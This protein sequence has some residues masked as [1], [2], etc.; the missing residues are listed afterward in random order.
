MKLIVEGR[1]QSTSATMLPQRKLQNLI[2]KLHEEGGSSRVR[3]ISAVAHAANHLQH[4][5]VPRA[6]GP[7]AI[8]PMNPMRT[9]PLTPGP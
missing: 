1:F 5:N 6:P 7:N 2:V 4:T 9:S 3:A 8:T